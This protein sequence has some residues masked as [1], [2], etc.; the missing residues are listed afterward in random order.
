MSRK[1]QTFEEALGELETIAEQIEKGEVGLEESIDKYERGMKLV[2]HCRDILTKAEH[3]IEMLQERAD[4][5]IEVRDAHQS[6]EGPA[7]P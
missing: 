6:S 5:T 7:E 4:G 1:K 3:R 2:K